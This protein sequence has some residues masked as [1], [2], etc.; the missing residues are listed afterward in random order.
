MLARKSKD[1]NKRLNTL[2]ER[3]ESKFRSQ[4]KSNSGFLSNLIVSSQGILS[5][6]ALI[7]DVFQ[8]ECSEEVTEETIF[9]LPGIVFAEIELVSMSK[10][11]LYT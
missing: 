11:N 9:D 3:I 10:L 5:D 7:K 4:R 1:L 2:I 6:F 8:L